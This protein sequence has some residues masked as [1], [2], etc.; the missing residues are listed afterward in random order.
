MAYRHGGVVC[1]VCCARCDMSQKGSMGVVAQGSGSTL[2]CLERPH[3][4]LSLE[5]LCSMERQRQSHLELLVV[6]SC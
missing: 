2:A 5:Q 1:A 4:G 6:Y 3:S